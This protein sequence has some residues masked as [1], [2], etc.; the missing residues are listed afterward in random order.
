MDS[1]SEKRSQPK[2]SIAYKIII[3]GEIPVRVMERLSAIHAQAILKVRS[4]VIADS[5]DHTECQADNA[6]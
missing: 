6:V 2:N 5:R 1:T 3:R 4:R